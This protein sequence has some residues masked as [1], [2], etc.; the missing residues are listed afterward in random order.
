MIEVLENL[1]KFILTHRFIR[2][3]L[4]YLAISFLVL[5]LSLAGLIFYKTN[6]FIT[7]LWLSFIKTPTFGYGRITHILS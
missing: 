1:V 2:I 4:N 6:F 3:T 7:T 5:Y